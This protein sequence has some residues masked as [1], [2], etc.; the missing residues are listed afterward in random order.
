MRIKI[1]QLR[2]IIKEEV[3]KILAEDKSI[4]PE[5]LD[6]E[7][8]ELQGPG[9]RETLMK[10]IGE[11]GQETFEHCMFV[12][13]MEDVELRAAISDDD[14]ESAKAIIDG[15]IMKHYPPGKYDPFTGNPVVPFG[16]D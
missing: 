7:Y 16:G 13:D 12:D 1:K 6:P 5:L 10:L 8:W 14:F 9:G 2:H 15:V 3:Q 4:N 11:Y